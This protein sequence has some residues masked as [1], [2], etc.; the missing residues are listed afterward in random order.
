M[1]IVLRLTPR[2]AVWWTVHYCPPELQKSLAVNILCLP[3]TLSCELYHITPTWPS[4]KLSSDCLDIRCRAGYDRWKK[5][6][7]QKRHCEIII[8]STLLFDLQNRRFPGRN[9]RLTLT[10]SASS[11]DKKRLKESSWGLRT[12]GKF[13]SSPASN[14]AIPIQLKTASSDSARFP[15]GNFLW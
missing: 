14:H 12:K 10:D 15:A 2:T 8:K 4:P 6:S 5:K 11:G 1:L 7:S 13:E 9:P 3:N